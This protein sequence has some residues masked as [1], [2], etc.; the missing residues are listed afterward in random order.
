MDYAN[1]G[2]HG[3]MGIVG[4]RVARVDFV[5]TRMTRP[6]MLFHFGRAAVARRLDALVDIGER[7]AAAAAVS[8]VVDL[9]GDSS[10]VLDDDG[11]PLMMLMEQRRLQLVAPGQ[12]PDD[13]LVRFLSDEAR[14]EEWQSALHNL[15]LA[16]LRVIGEVGGIA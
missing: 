14:R 5:P 7:A 8:P 15:G 9:I 10:P 1:F 16:D 12:P 11:S 13:V 4:D 6:Y 2:F 3:L